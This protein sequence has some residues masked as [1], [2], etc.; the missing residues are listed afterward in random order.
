MS[1]LSSPEERRKPVREV[2]SLIGTGYAAGHTETFMSDES[3]DV[4]WQ[5]GGPTSGKLASADVH[6]FQQSVGGRSCTF[7]ITASPHPISARLNVGSGGS[8][9]LTNVAS[10]GGDRV[11]LLCGCRPGDTVQLVLSTV[12]RPTA[13]TFTV[14]EGG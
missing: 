8:S 2:G 11:T 10:G 5:V 14:S 1:P 9:R 7:T 3:P 4:P 13:Y 12:G 6:R